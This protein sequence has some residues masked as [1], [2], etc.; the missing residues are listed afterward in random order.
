MNFWVTVCR[1]PAG[2]VAT[3]FVIVFWIILFPLET[4]ALLICFP[5]ASLI[6]T[7]GKMKDSWIGEYPNS[8]RKLGECL[9]KV[10]EWVFNDLKP[11]P[12]PE[13]K[14]DCFIV[15]AACNSNS[16]EVIYLSR[17][18]DEVL[19]TNTVGRGFIAFYYAISPKLS[20]IIY[21]CRPLQLLVRVAFIKPLV[22]VLHRF[23]L[24]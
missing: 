18:R 8:L 9:G 12:P 6:M 5:F 2:I 7:R 23:R 20:S 21:K 1:I 10:W 15:T 3:F 13:P 4:A 19:N 14:V 16:Y 11:E 17:L 24:P 22:S